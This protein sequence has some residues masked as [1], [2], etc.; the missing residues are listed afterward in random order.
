MSGGRDLRDP[1][2]AL[3]ALDALVLAGDMGAEARAQLSA[4]RA[5]VMR[6]QI[7][8]SA[9]EEAL[10]VAEAM[11]A[12]LARER[13]FDAGLNAGVGSGP[14]WLYQSALD[15]C[16]DALTITD[17]SDAPLYSNA[18]ARA[19]TGGRPRPDQGRAWH[20][21]VQM[22]Q[23]EARILGGERVVTAQI[24]RASPQGLRQCQVTKTPLI[25]PSGAVEAILTRL[26][27]ATE[28]RAAQDELRLSNLILDQAREAILLTDP[29]GMV[30]ALNPAF[31]RLTGF[32]INALQH[33]PISVLLSRK[34]GSERYIA[35]QFLENDH[36]QGEISLRNAAGT[37]ITLWCSA[38]RISDPS[39]R[40]I[41]EVVA[42]SDLTWLQ[43]NHAQNERLARV[44]M[45][46]GLSNRTA[47]QER[48]ALALLA[49]ER[50]WERFA[51]M[52]LDLD[53][54]KAVNDSL[55]H[56]AG[57]AV[58]GAVAARL[59]GAVEAAGDSALCAPAARALAQATVARIGG[60]EFV[61]L[62]PDCDRALA[63][64]LG[65]HLLAHLRAPI[66]IN[67]LESYRPSASLGVALYPEHGATGE[68]LLRAAD[69]AMYAAKGS[70][71]R[72]AF[73]RAVMRAQAAEMFALTNA[74]SGALERGEFELLYQPIYR[75]TDRAIVGAEALLRWNRP[76]F[77]QLSPGAFLATA[78]RAGLMRAID[79]W[80]LGQAL[81]DLAGWREGGAFG[82]GFLLSVNQTAEDLSQPD[83]LKTLE[84]LMARHAIASSG[85]MLQ[86]ELTE[87]YAAGTFETLHHNLDALSALGV[88]LAVDD[89]GT[90]YSNLSYLRR[91]PISML[92]I[93]RSFIHGLER[94]AEAQVLA[95]AIIGLGAQFEYQVLAEGVESEAQ[96][97]ALARM[98]CDYCQGFLL[99]RPMTAQALSAALGGGGVP[100]DPRA[101]SATGSMT[102]SESERALEE[103]ILR[104]VALDQASLRA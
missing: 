71:S 17:L 52:F 48:L 83:W 18:A 50:A 33:K 9:T 40:V 4:L 60:D 74:L 95:Q 61:I 38:T 67:D 72:I 29:E 31:E 97:A 64:D 90:G 76:G 80:V 75:I 10:R 87:A 82:A 23:M 91:L 26:H 12:A 92:K 22:R 37:E 84:G 55:G 59:L 86:I 36:W 21:E 63:Q 34:D 103:A 49:A 28:E 42:L 8:R 101:G 98:G 1:A 5:W 69:T 20:E 7:Q 27:D 73:Y 2:T 66:E 41:G 53:G 46:T 100:Q 88:R 85:A 77:G 43:K 14:A 30:R 13:G 45:L 25:S 6:A 32:G 104:A 62:L 78:E 24:A 56:A 79:A 81:R 70:A 94:D 57:D 35:A 102:G 44:D 99:A 47:M 51:V 3:D 89:F 16:P 68:E 39:G 19:E 11:R 65:A 93:D 54:F 15:H 58:L 96:L